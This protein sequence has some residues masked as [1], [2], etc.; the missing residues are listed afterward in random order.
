MTGQSGQ[1]GQSG[2]EREWV[3]RRLWALATAGAGALV[4]VA[5]ASC[6]AGDR[7][8]A[9]PT[10]EQTTTTFL[11][12]TTTSVAAVGGPTTAPV[13][14][15][16]TTTAFADGAPIPERH[17][18]TGIDVPPDL[19]WSNVPPGTVELA[20][21][22]DDPD[23]D[24]FVH[25]IVTGIDPAAAGLLGGQLPEGAV[26]A[27]NDSGDTGWAGPCPPDGT[28]VHHYRFQLYA[29]G[30]PLG[31]AAGT[32]PEE[33]RLAVINGSILQQAALSGTVAAAG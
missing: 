3:R 4:A 9:R 20:L 22:M 25:W 10:D 27:R 5:M 8:M 21:V 2:P 30:A 26:E 11:R 28:G 31:L 15:H 32:D 33:A 1:S 13:A 19:T 17:T 24:G 7:D 18:C 16:L 23:A 14:L 12:G 6:G 29:L